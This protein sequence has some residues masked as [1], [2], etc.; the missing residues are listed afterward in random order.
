MYLDYNGV[1]INISLLTPQTEAFLSILGSIDL[2]TLG[3]F[4]VQNGGTRIRHPMR[5]GVLGH[6]L[7]SGFESWKCLPESHP[8][9]KI[10]N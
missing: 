1:L 9:S 4:V 3:K 8:Q 2:G 7:L 10:K 6:S 5:E